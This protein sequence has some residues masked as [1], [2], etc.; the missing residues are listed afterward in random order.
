[1]LRNTLC[2]SFELE[3]DKPNFGHYVQLVI[4]ALTA[5]HIDASFVAA[6]GQ[7][8][9]EDFPIKKVQELYECRVNELQ[10]ISILHENMEQKLSSIEERNADKHKF[11]GQRKFGRFVNKAPKHR[12]NT[13][14]EKVA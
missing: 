12:L 6:I 11:R 7:M 8:G 2:H 13:V 1:M 5:V 9:E 4:D 14:V 3:I 10:A